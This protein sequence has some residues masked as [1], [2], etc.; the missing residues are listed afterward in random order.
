MLIRSYTIGSLKDI[1]LFP[2]LERVQFTLNSRMA[3]Q[4][5]KTVEALRKI[6]FSNTEVY[7]HYD[8]LR[9]IPR[10]LIM[11]DLG[12]KS[13][14][15]EIVDLIEYSYEQPNLKGVVIHMDTAFK[16]EMMADLT[17]NGYSDQSLERA[18]KK[19]VIST[20]YKSNVEVLDIVKKNRP[21]GTG[22][23]F[24]SLGQ[25]F[26][27][28][29]Y[30]SSVNEFYIDL[31]NECLLRGLDL[32]K[33]HALVYLENTTHIL[34]GGLDPKVD[35]VAG[36]LKH[37][38]VLTA[39]KF[40]LLGVCWDLEHGYAANDED[41]SVEALKDAHIINKNLLIHLNCIEKGVTKGSM[42]DRHSLT[43]VFECSVHEVKYYDELIQMLDYYKI[44]YIREVKS[45]TMER[46]M[47]QQTKYSS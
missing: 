4:K 20:M 30:T 27:H 39:S 29:W 37:N 44:P 22:G 17:C 6:R 32:N 13:M 31:K 40:D 41:I 23:K 16:K 24:K 42:K 3:P 12:K 5:R 8:F 2:F 38:A 28:N 21:E 1:D 10:Y 25:E 19:Y 7:V 33:P 14:I 43:T 15:T 36:S 35:C 47:M 45:E 9:T 18:C 26:L 46:E 11:T 34:T